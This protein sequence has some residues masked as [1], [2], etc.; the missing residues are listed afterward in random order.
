MYTVQYN[1]SNFHSYLAKNMV[2]FSDILKLPEPYPTKC[3]CWGSGGSGTL[4]IEH[5]K[6]RKIEL[7]PCHMKLLTTS[8][9]VSISAGYHRTVVTTDSGECYSW[10]KPPLGRQTSSI[11]SEAT[12]K[13]IQMKIPVANVIHGETHSII[14]A[15]DKSVYSFGDASEGK[16]GLP[17]K[18]R[19]QVILPTKI[20]RK[21]KCIDAACG[22]SSTVLLLN[23]GNDAVAFGNTGSKEQARN[24]KKQKNKAELDVFIFPVKFICIAGGT[25]HLAAVSYSGQCYTWGLSQ[26]GRLGHGNEDDYHLDMIEANPKR[27]EYFHDNSITVVGVFCGGAHTCVLGKGGKVFSFGW[28]VYFQC[29][30]NCTRE[31]NGDVFVPTKIEMKGRCIVDISCGFAHTAVIDTSG[32]LH[33]FG[34]NEEG[35]LGVGH[36]K[37]VEEP[38]EVDFGNKKDS[39]YT[40][41]VSAGKTHTA[42]IRSSCT[43][44]EFFRQIEEITAKKNAMATLRSFCN[45]IVFRK[46]IERLQRLRDSKKENQV[47]VTTLEM[48][49]NEET[50]QEAEADDSTDFS[51][52]SLSSEEVN[53]SLDL[54][55]NNSDEFDNFKNRQE[56]LHLMEYED[57]M[58]RQLARS[59][60]RYMNEV[61]RKK[62][63]VILEII[64]RYEIFC[65]AKEDQY[66]IAFQEAEKDKLRQQI[67]MMKE[68][69]STRDAKTKE[70][71]KK[72]SDRMLKAKLKQRPK[73]RQKK[74]RPGRFKKVIPDLLTFTSTREINNKSPE[75]VFGPSLNSERNRV[76]LLRRKGRMQRQEQVRQED[77][78]RKSYF[79]EHNRK[80]KN[81]MTRRAN[82]EVSELMA[83][84][85]K[86]FIKRR[87]DNKLELLQ[88]QNNLPAIKIDDQRECSYPTRSVTQWSK[89][90]S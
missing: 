2:D 4:G 55:E 25:S 17:K 56:E 5:G 84:I 24:R 42:C 75:N 27:V 61:R 49:S 37:N 85:N 11:T 19:G 15:K 72:E 73:Y 60:K 18:T 3:Y 38:V 30:I 52:F 64:R 88:M 39:K 50:S 13:K 46:H 14:I 79:D 32:G 8:P 9:I 58:S 36:E 20:P 57:M 34:F 65:M 83:S 40:I 71:I 47:I 67:Q 23:D 21:E 33:V 74:Y 70:H 63:S 22:F 29:G 80:K 54:N 90:L 66:S 6:L 69:K 7:R 48:S 81:M 10:G 45:Q 44:D 86:M 68:K 1:I 62:T 53:I 51:S 76:L 26:N 89:D 59:E 82:A 12:A 16:L 41:A 31:K 35:Q 77:N 28:N 78:E 87:A 43:R